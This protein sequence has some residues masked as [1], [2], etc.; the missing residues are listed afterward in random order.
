MP[1][2]NITHTCNKA[3]SIPPPSIVEGLYQM[4]HQLQ[5]QNRKLLTQMAV[6]N[7]ENVGRENEAS[8]HQNKDDP[9][10]DKEEANTQSTHKRDKTYQTTIT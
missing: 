10:R 2:I 1:T 5:D 4:I 9:T 8:S 3:N 6:M 7:L